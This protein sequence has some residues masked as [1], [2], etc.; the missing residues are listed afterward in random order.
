MSE[1]ELSDT[2]NAVTSLKYGNLYV[3]QYKTEKETKKA[4]KTK[5]GRWK[6]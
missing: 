4:K 3:L 6:T 5:K 1:K 2:Y